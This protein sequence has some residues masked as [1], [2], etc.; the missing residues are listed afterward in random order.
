MTQ[1]M[2]D[3]GG[4]RTDVD[5]GSAHAASMSGSTTPGVQKAPVP[6]MGR[7]GARL[8]RRALL[9]ADATGLLLA[10]L[11]TEALFRAADSEH[12]G[13]RKE[14][15][16]F[17]LTLPLWLLAAD[18]YGLYKRD[19]KRADHS[20]VDDFVNVFHL[21][22]VGVWT[23]FAGSWFTGLAYP[24]AKKLS[25]FW[26]LGIVLVVVARTIARGFIRTRASY[27]QRALIVG[28]GDVGQLVGRKLLHHPE[29]GI[30]LVGFVDAD[31]KPLRAEVR[32]LPL[33]GDPH[34][35]PE[36]VQTLGIDHV[37]IAFTKEPHDELLHVIHSMRQLPVQIDLVPRLFEAVGPAVEMHTV[38]GIPL[39][40]L[41]PVRKSYKSRAA[42]RAIDIVGSVVGLVLLAPLLLVIA[43]SIKLDSPGPVFYRQRRLGVQM[44]QFT[45]LKF[46]TMTT[47]TSHAPHREYIKAIMASDASAG[48][49]QM[50]KLDRSE[51]VTRAGYWLRRF[52]LDELPQLWN[53]LRG[54]MSLVGPRP[55]LPYE[56][57]HF[58][59]HHFERFAVPGGITGLWQVSARAH[60]TFGEALEMDVA[61]VRSWSVGLDLRLLFRTPLAI[62]RTTSTK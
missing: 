6:T 14:T 2:V 37:V 47:D 25:T 42:K 45:L 7:R 16:I 61:Y 26:L 3:D 30:E 35:L 46:R 28:A 39:I 34:E 19:D 29:Y 11:L 17:V 59:P 56:T 54:E 10:F 18:L 23:F 21:I 57:E 40:G 55:C 27:V 5:L 60:S 44:G 15:V 53:V 9:A 62:L 4:T 52:S 20:T 12:L 58:E 31:P 13:V 32:H 51:N 48:A 36:L 50:Y 49:D 43:I 8:L 24:D 41:T 33:L 38:E 22:T 1:K